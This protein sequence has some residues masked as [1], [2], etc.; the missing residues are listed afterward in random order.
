MQRTALPTTE[1]SV[2][3]R[4]NKIAKLAQV[5]ASFGTHARYKA[6]FYSITAVNL[7]RTNYGQSGKMA[8]LRQDQNFR[9]TGY[10]A[11][12]RGPA[13]SLKQRHKLCTFLTLLWPTYLPLYVCFY[14]VALYVLLPLTQMKTSHAQTKPSI[15]QRVSFV[16]VLSI[17]SWQTICRRMQ[18]FYTLKLTCCVTR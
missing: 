2:T 4:R 5:L 10:N 9:Y 15:T 3:R 18:A 14:A 8:D 11:D 7:L 1:A 12:A 16:A 17:G 13:E 6:A